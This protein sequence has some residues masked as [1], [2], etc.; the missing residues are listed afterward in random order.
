MSVVE[1]LE[2]LRS[3]LSAGFIGAGLFFVFVGAIGILRLPDFYTR[4]HAAGVTDTLGAELILIG[5]MIT[6]GLSIDTLKLAL[7][8][9]FLFLTSPT[10]TH[11]VANAAFTSGLE[12]QLGRYRPPRP[13][14]PPEEEA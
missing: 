11:A 1:I 9:L 6:S 8:A 2:L 12:P 3:L 7:I 13:G 4:I 14:Q 10:A 5:L